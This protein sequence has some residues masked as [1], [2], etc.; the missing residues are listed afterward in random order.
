MLFF[1]FRARSWPF[2][3]EGRE[4]AHSSLGAVEAGVSD[5]EGRHSDETGAHVSVRVAGMI[6]NETMIEIC[7]NIESNCE[8]NSLID[9]VEASRNDGGG[10]AVGSPSEASG[11]SASE[12]GLT[13]GK[14]LKREVALKLKGNNPSDYGRSRCGLR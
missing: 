9:L 6:M 11:T 1:S 8:D 13:I 12:D 3:G 7:G 14:D 4:E 10:L 2:L 5:G